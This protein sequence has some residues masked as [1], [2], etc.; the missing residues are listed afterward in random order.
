MFLLLT[1]TTLS[2]PPV[3]AE[4]TGGVTGTVTAEASKNK[5]NTVVYV[6]VGDKGPATTKT[7]GMDQTGLMFSPHVLPIQLGWTVD[8]TNS[9]PVGHNVFTMDGEKYDLG[10]WPQ[11]EKRSYVFTKA[12][13]YRQLCRV[14][15]DMLAYVLV[16]DTARFA[17]SDKDGN[18]MLAGLPP[19]TYTLGVWH[20]KLKAADLVVTVAAGQN[21]AATIPLVAK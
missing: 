6:K 7:V 18:F 19:G 14:H 1:L 13:T 10:T 21:A 8:F 12:G 11:G 9:D 4:S 20:E 5:V 15:D 2:S 17:V 16:L 3:L